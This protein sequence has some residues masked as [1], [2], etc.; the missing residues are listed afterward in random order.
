MSEPSG[1]E[2][3]DDSRSRS[4]RPWWACVLGISLLAGLVGFGAGQIGGRNQFDPPAGASVPLRG[5]ENRPTQTATEKVAL[6]YIGRGDGMLYRELRELPVRGAHNSTAVLAL[7]EVASVD[8]DYESFW[9]PATWVRISE[10]EGTVS[11]DLPSEAFRNIDSTYKAKRAV[12][13]LSATL[14]ES[15]GERAQELDLKLLID[16]DP[17]LP[18]VFGKISHMSAAVAGL[19]PALWLTDPVNQSMVQEG[20]IRIAGLVRQGSP[21]PVVAVKAGRNGGVTN[22]EVELVGP[23]DQE[24]NRWEAEMEAP[25]GTYGITASTRQGNAISSDTKVLKVAATGQ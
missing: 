18:E 25:A 5:Q 12:A 20:R 19:K 22:P 11:V 17:Q 4:S 9:S 23:W 15:M 16:G 13:Q 10:G 21:K 14:I 7:T 3:P 24:W 1:T 6:Y 2:L 8:P